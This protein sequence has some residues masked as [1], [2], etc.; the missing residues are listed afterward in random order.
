VFIVPSA[1]WRWECDERLT[2]GQE[3]IKSGG[4]QAVIRRP[5]LNAHRREVRLLQFFSRVDLLVGTCN[6]QVGITN[7]WACSHPITRNEAI[8]MPEPPP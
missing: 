2:E 6:P 4:W 7:G 8:R 5:K 3:V 1:H